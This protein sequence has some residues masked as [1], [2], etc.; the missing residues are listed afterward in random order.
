MTDI[1]VQFLGLKLKNPLIIA[2]GPLTRN[3]A[4]M[5]KAVEAGVGAVVTETIANEASRNVRPRLV[6]RG[7]GLQNIR[8]YSEYSLEEWAREMKLIE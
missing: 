4:A 3:G 8:L 6:K 1:S 7:G 2:A 5:K